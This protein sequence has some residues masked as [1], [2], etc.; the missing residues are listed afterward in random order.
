[1]RIKKYICRIKMLLSVH[2]LFQPIR[3]IIDFVKKMVQITIKKY[4]SLAF[5]TRMFKF[6]RNRLS[7]FVNIFIIFFS[8]SVKLVKNVKTSWF[9]LEDP[10]ESWLIYGL[11]LCACV[12]KFHSKLSLSITIHTVISTYVYVCLPDHDAHLWC[13]ASLL[14]IPCLM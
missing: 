10:K 13:M 2:I 3:F 9:S 1:M 11:V 6:V 4:Y 12:I 7:K 14:T 5:V 8:F